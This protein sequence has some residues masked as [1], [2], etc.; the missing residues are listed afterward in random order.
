MEPEVIPEVKT[1]R[2]LADSAIVAEEED[3]AED[4]V[5]LVIMELNERNRKTMTSTEISSSRSRQVKLTE[6]NA[7]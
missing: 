7:G 4:A 2:T 6:M 1:V 5:E 3:A